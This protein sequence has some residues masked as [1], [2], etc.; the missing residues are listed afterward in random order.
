MLKAADVNTL[1][2]LLTL[3]N[4]IWHSESPPKQWKTGI[5]L[6]LHLKGVLTACNSWRGIN[7]LSVSSKILCSVFLE[8]LKKSVDGILIEEQAGFRPHNSCID[9]IYLHLES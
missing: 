3:F 9:Q 5:T 7:L 1:H 2:H 6:K 4:D 8:K